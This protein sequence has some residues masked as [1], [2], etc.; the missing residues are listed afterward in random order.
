MLDGFGDMAYGKRPSEIMKITLE[1]IAPCRKKL[2]IEVEAERVAGARAEILQEFRKA[3]QVP[4][5]RP[6]KAPEPIV[7]AQYSRQIEEEL[8]KRLIPETYRQAIAEQKVRAVGFPQIESVE[9]ERGKP[10]VYAALVDTAP[11]FPVPEYKGIPLKKTQAILTDEEV[12]HMLESLRDQHADFVAVEGRGLRTGDFA[13][14]NYTGVADGKPI[15]EL[16]PDVKTLGENKEFWLLIQSDAFLPGFCDQLLGTPV[17]ERR[18]VLVDF[19]ADFPQKPLAGRKATYFVEVTAIK[20]KKLPELNEEFAKK[21]GA[22]NLDKL[23]EDLRK[24]MQAE[25]DRQVDA[26]LRN[27]IIGFLL[28]KAEF[29]LPES[30]VTQETRSIIYDVVREQTMQ[31]A[32]KEQLEEKKDEIY[33]FATRNAKDRLR[34]SFILD[35]IA[36]AEQIKVE[37]A[38]VEAR[39]AELAKRARVTVE[40]LKAELAE[41]EAESEIEEQ[42]RVRKT[43]DLLLA[44]AKIESVLPAPAAPR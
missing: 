43:L 10:M 2:R 41:R 40:K 17:G 26:D 3:A 11:E 25:R 14:V 12:T 8:R 20:E 38:E 33:G 18:Q 16:V 21:V 6:G 44:H 23:R 19:P 30:L 36:E 22:E 27:Q 4:G 5:F 35:A 39:L 1:N 42:V 31:G 28:G 32:T 29:E 37:P 13:V 7:E 34:S 24:H 15:S 9:W